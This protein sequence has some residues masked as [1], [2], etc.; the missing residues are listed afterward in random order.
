M[1]LNWLL[2]EYFEIERENKIL[3]SKM[4]KIMKGSKSLS[5]IQTYKQKPDLFMISNE[6]CISNYKL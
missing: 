5:E 6:S 2:G 4:S 3:L 1:V